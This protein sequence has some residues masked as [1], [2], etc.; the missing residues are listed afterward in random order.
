M[1]KDVFVNLS[2]NKA[3]KVRQI[4]E[5]I[6]SLVRFAQP[7]LGQV[8]LS[9]N[10]YSNTGS[11]H[12]VDDLHRLSHGIS[13]NETL[14]INDK[15][16]EWAQNQ[17]SIIPSNIAKKKIVT[18]VFDNIDWQNKNGRIE[19]SYIFYHCSER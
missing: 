7:T 5:N 13:Y 10:M 2:T 12:I 8:L 1:G 6:Q 18:H 9:L 16:A 17:S 14:F 15:W 3:I 4:C 19:T 11:K